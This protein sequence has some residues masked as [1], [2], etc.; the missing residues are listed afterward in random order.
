MRAA[1]H[2]EQASP[3]IGEGFG[4]SAIKLNKVRIG[5]ATVGAAFAGNEAKRICGKAPAVDVEAGRDRRTSW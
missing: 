2:P 3:A 5:C 4:K 1:F